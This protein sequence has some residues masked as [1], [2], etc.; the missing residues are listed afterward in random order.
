MEPIKKQASSLTTTLNNLN[1]SSSNGV[2]SFW[3]GRVGGAGTCDLAITLGT[4][5]ITVDRWVTTVTNN[6]PNWQ[7]KTYDSITP[8]SSTAD[9]MFSLTCDKI[10]IDYTIDDVSFTQFT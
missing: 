4:T 10:G 1:T 7:L 3:Y 5:S 2:L 6:K 8:P 9:L